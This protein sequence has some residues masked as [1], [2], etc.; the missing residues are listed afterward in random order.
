ME[1]QSH[2]G[3]KGDL[4]VQPRKR[5]LSK[6]LRKANL[7]YQIFMAIIMP[8]TSFLLAI[9]TDVNELY[10]QIISFITPIIPVVWSNILDACKKYEDELTP[11][12]TPEN[13]PERATCSPFR[14]TK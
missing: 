1:R 2:L 12:N 8:I 13:S 7:V 14:E 5:K 9:G 3:L 4:E 10:F 11:E 6:T